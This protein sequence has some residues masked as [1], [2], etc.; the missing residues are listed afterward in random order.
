V[1]CPSTGET[2]H[3]CPGFI[4]DHFIPLCADGADDVRNM[5]RED[6]V[7]AAE[8]DRRELQL[9]HRQR[10]IERN[11][12]DPALRQRVMVLYLR[13]VETMGGEEAKAAQ[14]AF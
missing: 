9:C 8:K 10:L 13:D 12:N 7:H 4:R 3:R 6:I 5:W 11:S 14:Q 1:P 2:G